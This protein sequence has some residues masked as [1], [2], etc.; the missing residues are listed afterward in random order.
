[1]HLRN[2]F[3][4]L[5]LFL[6]LGF[7]ARAQE[8]PQV[9][10]ISPAPESTVVELRFINVIFDDSVFG[11][12]ASDL[13]INAAPAS[14]IV[15][16]NP[17]DYTFYFPQPPTGAVQ[18]AWAPNHG[19]T[20]YQMPPDP[21]VG[22]NWSYILDT[23]SAPRPVVVLSEF[24][25][26]NESGVQ[27]EDGTRSDWIELLNRGPLEA[28]LSGWYLTDDRLNL[29]KWQFPLGMSPLNVNAYLRIWASEKDRRPPIR[30]RSGP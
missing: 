21:F 11:I 6:S 28:N 25:A 7:A 26:D 2:S 19:I 24:M 4:V 29:T 16:N 8:G 14:S 20:G 3:L 17:N 9:S 18:I 5:S 13:L 15:T 10:N 1:M 22:Q 30:A 27:D 12:N 23:N